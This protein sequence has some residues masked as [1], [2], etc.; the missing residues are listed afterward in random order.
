MTLDGY[1]K[2]SNQVH[3]SDPII[4]SYWMG[5]TTF[6]NIYNARKYAVVIR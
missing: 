2:G 1:N 6:E 4:G 5:R 3:V